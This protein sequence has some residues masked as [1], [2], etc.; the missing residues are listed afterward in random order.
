MQYRDLPMQRNHTSHQGNPEIFAARPDTKCVVADTFC[1]S[2]RVSLSC[3][4]MKSPEELP[5]VRKAAWMGEP[6]PERPAL[7]PQEEAVEIARIVPRLEAIVIRHLT[8][9]R[10][11]GIQLD[12]A[13]VGAVISALE[14]EAGGKTPGPLHADEIRRFAMESLYEELL[15]EPSNVFLHRR[16][17]AETT[18]YEAMQR[19]F[20]RLCLAELRRRCKV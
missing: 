3:S 10:R 14:T 11:M 12:P 6:A 15:A 9:A 13:D 16:V 5:H 18:R 1:G 19:S 8:S 20:W 4:P 17:D 7:T 2:P